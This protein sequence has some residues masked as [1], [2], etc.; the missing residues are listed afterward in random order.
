MALA[1][2]TTCRVQQCWRGWRRCQGR[3]ILPF[4]RLSYATPSKHSWWEDDG[5]KRTVSQ[6][7]GEKQD[8]PLMPLQFSICIQGAL[9]EVSVVLQPGEQLCAFLDDVYALCQLVR[10]KFI[11]EGGVQLDHVD[12]WERMQALGIVVLGTPIGSGTVHQ[13]KVAEPH[14]RG[15]RLW[16][17]IPNVVGKSCCSVPTHEPYTRCALSLH[18]Y[19]QSMAATMTRAFGTQP[20]H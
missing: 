7:E 17:T 15:G 3:S 11:H 20:G 5:Q 4:V 8:D 2:M 18:P 13:S 12:T 9:E 6:A 10:E 16:E 1:F 19:H 14:R